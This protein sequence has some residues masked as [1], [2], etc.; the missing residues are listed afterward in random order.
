MKIMPE[1]CNINLPLQLEKMRKK[2]R[3][4]ISRHGR[5]NSIKKHFNCRWKIEMKN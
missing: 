2:I 3:K 1:K 4:N 5:K